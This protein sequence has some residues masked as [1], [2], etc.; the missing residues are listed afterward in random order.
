M[1][2]SGFERESLLRLI[3]SPDESI[4][5]FL[6][7]FLEQANIREEDMGRITGYLSAREIQT[8]L[9]FPDERGTIKVIVSPVVFSEFV[10]HLNMHRKLHDKLAEAVKCIAGDRSRTLAKVKIRNARKE[11]EGKRLDFLCLFFKK[12]GSEEESIFDEC[13]ESAM[14]ILEAADERSDIYQA[15]SSKK[16]ACFHS[17]INAERLEELLQKNN[18]E[19]LL[20]QGV[21]PVSIDKDAVLRKMEII[22]RICIAVFGKTEYYEKSLMVSHDY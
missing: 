13:L 4:Q 11:F 21:R 16:G 15:L 8:K 22:D 6:E 12:M 20:L 19:T 18:I 3:F 17:L 9:I 5:I 7:E 14:G 1:S 10:D 2:G